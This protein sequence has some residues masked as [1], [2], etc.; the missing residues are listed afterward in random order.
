MDGEL[1]MEGT[2]MS[3]PT[4]NPK[5]GNGIPVQAFLPGELHGQSRLA[6]YSPWGCKSWTQLNMYHQSKSKGKFFCGSVKTDKLIPR[7]RWNGS[8][9]KMRAFDL[10]D[11]KHY[12]IT[13]LNICV[14]CIYP[15]S[16][17]INTKK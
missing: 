15:F 16:A 6:G 11:I 13:V 3:I 14:Q 4:Q 1:C 7:A 9:R 2:K 5:G 17:G 12:K 10:Q 8:T